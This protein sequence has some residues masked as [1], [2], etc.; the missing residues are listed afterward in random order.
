MPIAS[1][2]KET[3]I[4]TPQTLIA[5]LASCALLAFVSACSSSVRKHA[6]AASSAQRAQGRK[7]YV[8]ACAVCH[9]LT[10]HDTHAEG[11]DLG[12]LEM[13]EAQMVSFARIMPIPKMTKGELRMLARY[14]VAAEADEAKLRGDVPTVP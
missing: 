6:N 5:A 13:S 3:E 4:D 14:V 8:H 11:G 2:G 9:T 10:G 12:V 7:L 1:C